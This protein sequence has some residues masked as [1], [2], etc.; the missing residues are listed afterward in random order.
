M[1]KQRQKTAVRFWELPLIY[2]ITVHWLELSDLATPNCAEWGK[3]SLSLLTSRHVTYYGSRLN[4]N[5]S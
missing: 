1:Q 5:L 2:L 3:C 4:S